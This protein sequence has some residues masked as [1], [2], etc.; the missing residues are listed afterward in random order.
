M[1]LVAIRPLIVFSL[2]IASLNLP[3]PPAR[4]GLQS[5]P[6]G[7]VIRAID[8]DADGPVVRQRY[9]SM[10]GLE[11]GQLLT[12]TGVRS[13]IQR[14]YETGRFD[15]IAVDA[16]RTADGVRVLFRLRFSYYF[17]DFSV[18]GNLDTG[19]R[20]LTELVELP[21]GERYTRGRLEESREAV[22]GFLRAQGYY[23]ARVEARTQLDPTDFQVNTTFEIETGPQATLGSLAISGVP[24]NEVS[25]IRERL[26]LKQ[27]ERYSSRRLEERL[28]GLRA[29]LTRR[30][31]LGARPEIRE[32]FSEADNRVRLDL[33]FLN[34]G[35]VRVVL[36]GFKVPDER[37]SRLLPILSGEGL[38][39]DL[40]EEGRRNLKEYLEE[41]G[42]S[43]AE[44]SY[45]QEKQET[46]G[47]ILRYRVI[48]GRRVS[49]A[50]V[51]FRGNRAVPAKDLQAAIQIR[52]QGFM[53]KS[54]Y[55]IAKLDADVEAI[56]SLYRSRGYLENE[57][58]PLVEPIGNAET[59]GIVFEVVEG[60]PAL[61]R[62]VTITGNQVMASDALLAR[63]RL[64]AGSGFSPTLAE[65]DRQ[66]LLAVYNDA[67]YLRARV[68]YRV[69]DP[70]SEGARPVE[71]RVDEGMRSFVDRVLLFGN[72]HTRDSVIT[73]RIG[74]GDGEPLSLGRMLKTQQALSDLGV[75]D[76]V[77]VGPQFQESDA[78][79]QN[80]VVRVKESRRYTVR[81]G[82][83][84]ETRE[85]VRGTLE[86]SD[87]N[88]LGLAK[89]ADLR[90][91]ASAV[92]QA[93]ILTF[94]QSQ[95]QFLPVNSYLSLSGSA[96]EDVSFDQTRFNISYQFSRPLSTHSWALLRTNYRNVRVSN[97]QVSEIL[98]REDRPR[99]LTTLSAIYVND[100][101]D[102]FLDAE[103]GFFTSTDFSVTT[104]W[105][106][107][108]NYLSLYTQTSYYRRIPGNLVLATSLRLGLGRPYGRDDSIP[109][110]ERYFAGGGSSL[111]GFETDRAGPV[112]P[113]TGEPTGGNS[114]LIGNLELRLPLVR[115]VRLA[116]FYDGGNVFGRIGDI[117]LADFSHTVGVGLRVKTPLGP[118]RLDYGYNLN[119][120]E[121]LKVHGYKPG[122][123]FITIGPPF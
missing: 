69:G 78:A 29:Y 106:G 27:G 112:D 51:L 122:H 120:P 19:G 11:V 92:E 14:L 79:Y 53:Q 52:P 60:K 39:P 6:F 1:P 84:Y 96:E 88:L 10:I 37:R 74:L 82:L 41:R 28:A 30:G 43:E 49:V 81:Y 97:L 9:D 118:L 62:S 105:L 123:F 66:T 17:N 57:V 114:L 76:N 70:D 116:G 2:L 20:S 121:R 77:L 64:R 42:Y 93:A 55:S 86:L 107:S 102:N 48:P 63:L 85:K 104:R 111:R 99:N 24:D 16:A 91:R 72:D 61:T 75:F 26:G 56:K 23:R 108:N 33:N 50:Y 100:T 34:F 103:R 18:Q 87:I 54:V 113:E 68:V 117:R 89:R 90:F 4:A 35:R 58:V 36:E 109:I 83:G 45:E 80:L 71:F 21:V 3:A 119:V 101:R 73:R 98:A 13:A 22:A 12:R 5:G 15:S 40:L 46:G 7:E 38:D 67:G 95:V 32:S 25:A 44:V 94:Q 31:Y 115:M 8:Y 110:S 59:L 47:L 65:Q